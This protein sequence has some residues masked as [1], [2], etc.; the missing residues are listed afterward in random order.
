MRSFLA[1]LVISATMFLPFVCEA[2]DKFRGLPRGAKVIESRE[3]ES[4]AHGKRTLVLWMLNP[5]KNPRDPSE[6]Q[7]SCPEYTRGSHY[8]GATRVSLFDGARLVN[9]VRVRQYDEP[10]DSFDIPYRIQQ[11]YYYTVKDVPA[12]TE[13]TPTIIDLKDYNGDGRAAEF[14]LFQAQACMGLPTTLIGYS[15]RQDRVIQYPIRMTTRERGKRSVVMI[16]KWAD[17]LFSKPP[18]RAGFWQYEIDYRGRAG[19]L[20]RWTVRYN[21]RQERFDA[22]VTYIIGR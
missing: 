13:G 1:S 15:E 16:E 4:A 18:S 19:A 20:A 8:T 5:K 3:I 17:Y 14:A 7:Y 11:G 12:K 9:T 22:T 10:G 2:Q 21:P 6:G